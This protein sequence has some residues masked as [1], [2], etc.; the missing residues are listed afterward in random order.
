MTQQLIENVRKGLRQTTLFT[1]E[2]QEILLQLS[3][4]LSNQSPIIR[5]IYVSFK[6]NQ[7]PFE[8]KPM[9]GAPLMVQCDEV[10]GNYSIER[11]PSKITLNKEQ[12]V[13]WL[14]CCDRAFFPILPIGT[15]VSLDQELLSEEIRAQFEGH[16]QELL[17]TLTGRKIPVSHHDMNGVI[18]YVG[19]IYPMGTFPETP[20]V[21]LTNVMIKQV[22]HQ[23]L[24]TEMEKE[25]A[26][27]LKEQQLIESRLS[28]T[29]FSEEG[30]V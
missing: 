9:L 7:W 17:V 14:A 10:T 11:S 22:K 18:D 15:T 24:V 8:Y 25:M 13:H 1:E 20:V 3:I 30:E 12:F 5:D 23:G 19:V 21:V 27:N 26:E 16:R 2:E 4:M 29:Y 28:V 6:L